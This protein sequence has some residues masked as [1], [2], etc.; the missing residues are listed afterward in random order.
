MGTMRLW[1]SA[2]AVTA[3]L[4]A[5]VTTAVLAQKWCQQDADPHGVNYCEPFYTES[6]SIWTQFEGTQVESKC[7][8]NPV[9]EHGCYNHCTYRTWTQY[10]YPYSTVCVGYNYFLQ[11]GSRCVYDSWN[12]ACWE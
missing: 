10:K 9:W 1:S 7:V 12:E 4:L 2:L 8:Y 3:V 11:T 5:N 6:Y